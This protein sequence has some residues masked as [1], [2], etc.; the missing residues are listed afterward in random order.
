[1]FLLNFLLFGDRVF[2]VFFDD[3][4]VADALQYTVHIREIN[5]V[6]VVG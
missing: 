1:M 2:L 3:E 5:E 6:G 4:P